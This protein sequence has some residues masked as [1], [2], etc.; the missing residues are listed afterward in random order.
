MHLVH[1]GVGQNRHARYT[2]SLRNTWPKLLSEEHCFH[3]R[4]DTSTRQVD[5]SAARAADPMAVTFATSSWVAFTVG[6][7]HV[8]TLSVLDTRLRMNPSVHS[9]SMPD[10]LKAYVIDRA[11]SGIAY[12]LLS[13]STIQFTSTQRWLSWSG[14]VKPCFGSSFRVAQL[15]AQK[16]SMMLRRS[17]MLGLGHLSMISSTSASSLPSCLSFSGTSVKTALSA[18]K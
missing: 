6:R 5:G 1:Q 9:T 4:N 15:I 12:P 14:A 2:G 18:K 16:S 11:S 17:V 8:R 13:I 3:P 7:R 10:S